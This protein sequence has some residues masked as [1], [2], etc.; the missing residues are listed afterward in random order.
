M[1]GQVVGKS[2]QLL[3]EV[4]PGISR[5]AVLWNPDNTVFQSQLLREAQAAAA[6]L[7]VQLQTFGM[8]GPDGLAE[9]CGIR[10][11]RDLTAG[12]RRNH[13]G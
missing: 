6:V 1:T 9:W 10:L 7:G 8:Q 3:R 13:A 11:P 5:V 12:S 4:A 2:L